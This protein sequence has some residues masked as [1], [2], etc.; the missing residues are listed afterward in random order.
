M[1]KHKWS[2]LRHV[3]LRAGFIR[4]HQGEASTLDRLRQTRVSAFDRATF[5]RV[6]TIDA[7]DLAFENRVPMRQLELCAHF[8]MALET[9]LRRFP[10]INDTAGAAAGCNVL[11][12]RS[13]ARFATHLLGVIPFRLQPRMR[14]GP[15]VAH[16]FAVAGIAGIGSDKLGAGNARRRDDGA[17]GIEATTREK[18]YG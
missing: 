9:G 3:T 4:A 11:A 16:D 12:P 5:M 1:F 14:G 13:V 18:N 15:E 2:A 10:W 17:V 8:E 6:V 7:A